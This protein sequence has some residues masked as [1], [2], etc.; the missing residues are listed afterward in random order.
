MG[1]QDEWKVLCKR[2]VMMRGVGRIVWVNEKEMKVEIVG[3]K[4]GMK[5]KEG[6]RKEQMDEIG[7]GR[8][9]KGGYRV[10]KGLW[11]KFK[12]VLKMYGMQRVDEDK[13]KLVGVEGKWWLVGVGEER[14]DMIGNFVGVDK[15]KVF[16]GQNGGF[17]CKVGVEGK[18]L[19]M[20][21]KV[22]EQEG[23]SVKG[24][25]LEWKGWKVVYMGWGQKSG[26]VGRGVGDWWRYSFIEE[27]GKVLNGRIVFDDMEKSCC[28]MKK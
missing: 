14:N 16:I 7:F 27:I 9:E 15:R 3:G 24:K 10:D 17:M 1:K 28:V 19:Y 4:W 11:E 20:L 26:E 6:M 13:W 23:F 22:V 8:G 21:G 18:V 25:D 12:E 5:L 2:E